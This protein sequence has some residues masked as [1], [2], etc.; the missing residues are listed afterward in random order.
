M[1]TGKNYVKNLGYYGHEQCLLFKLQNILF[2]A[3]QEHGRWTGIK[4]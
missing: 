2:Y 1:K 4:D 3:V